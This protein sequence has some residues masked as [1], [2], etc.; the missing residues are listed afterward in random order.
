MINF[1]IRI[2]DCGPHCLLNLLTS[3]NASICSTKLLPSL[4][5]SDHAIISVSIDFLSYSKWGAPFHCIA[6]D[7]FVVIGIVLEYEVK[8][9][10]SSCFLTACV[11]AIS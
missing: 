11:A 7:I 6:Y 9:H 5:N 4:G 10:S 3:Y 2:P 8:T 1:P